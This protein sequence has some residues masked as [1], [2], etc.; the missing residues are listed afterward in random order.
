MAAAALLALLAC[1]A[2]P[3]GA[4]ADLTWQGL[5]TLS[6]GGSNTQQAT[7]AMN[8]GGEA[9]AAWYR[10][11]N[12]DT[13]LRPAGGNFAVPGVAIPGAGGD[14][15]DV[16][17]GVNG[18]AQAV[19]SSSDGSN[20][21]AAG[22]ARAPGSGFGSAGFI[23]PAGDNAGEPPV[24][25]VAP[26]G[27]AVALYRREI[28]EYVMGNSRA[29]GSSTWSS[30]SANPLSAQSSPF[31]TTSGPAAVAMDPQ[32]NAVA[33]WWRNVNNSPQLVEVRWRS[34]AGAWGPV[35]TLE[36][37]GAIS[38]YGPRVAMDGQGGA[39]AVWVGAGNVPHAA[40]RAPGTNSTFVSQ[41]VPAPATAVKDPRVAMDATGNGILTW[42]RG[43]RVEAAVR[44]AG[45]SF[46]A[47]SPISASGQTADQPALAMSSNGSAL[48]VWKQA[49]A[50][51]RIFGS[52]RPAAGNFSSQFELTDPVA[53]GD[54]SFPDVTMDNA[55]NA[56]AIWTRF[57]DG[58]VRVQ[59]RI[60][61]APGQTAPPPPPP[62]PEPPPPPPPVPG[63]PTV[64]AVKLAE[65]MA[66]DKAIVLTAQT[67]GPVDSVAWDLPIGAHIVGQT[68]SGQ[69]QRSV[70]FRPPP[71]AWDVRVRA[72]GAGRTGPLFTRHLASLRS[73]QDSETRRILNGLGSA[74]VAAVG[75]EADL[76]GGASS[77]SVRASG[78]CSIPTHIEAGQL[79]LDG[80]FKPVEKIADIPSAERGVLDTVARNVGIP[81]S[82]AGLMNKAMG[83]SDGYVAQGKA[84]L[85]DN[86]PVVPT[87]AA[88]IMAFPQARALTSSSASIEVAGQKFGASPKGFS[89]DLNPKKAGIDLGDIPKP[90]KLPSIG[91]FELVGDWNVDLGK[92]EATIKASLKLPKWITSAG[93]EIQNSVTLRATPE[94]LKVEDVSVGPIKANLGGLDVT[95]FKISFT[96]ATDTWQ[97]QA[98]A[99][100]ASGL[101]LDMVPPNGQVKI[102]HGKLNFAG[103]SLQFP[104]PGVP[105]FTG[106]NLERIGFGIGLDPTRF[107]GNA[108][109]AVLRLVKLDGR[110][111]VAFP[112][113]RTP[114]ILAADEVGGGFPAKLYGQKFTRPVIG[115]TAAVSVALP[116]L[117]LEL[118]HGYFLYHFPSYIAVGGGVSQNIL[119]VVSFAGGISGE[120]NFS[121]EVINVH[122]DI[123]VCLLHPHICGGAA[124]NI[125]RGPNSAGG[126]GGCVS[127]G[128]LSVGG[129]VLWRG[130]KII[131]WPLDGC[132]WSRFKLDVNA[133]RAQA[134][135]PRTIVVKA[136][137]PSPVLKLYGQGGAP[138]VHVAGPGGQV[139]DTTDR[140]LDY[141]PDAK[142]RILR[143]EGQNYNFTTI[144]I[145]HGQPG[146][147]T[148]TP[149][150]G[151][152]PI[153]KVERATDQPNAGVTGHVT[154]RGTQRVL[155]YRVLKRDGQTV[156]F[157]DVGEG[158]ASR[159]IGH[160]T[161]GGTGAIKFSAAPGKA[162]RRVEAQFALDG[163]NA[164][165]KVVT[166]FRPPA[167]T[168]PVPRGLRVKRGK[169]GLT[170]SWRGVAGASKYE[171]GI[172]SPSGYQ[173]IIITRKR[174][175]VVKLAKSVGGR[176]TVRA[177]APFRTSRVTAKPFRRLASRATKFRTP[178]RCRVVKKR[179][180]C[181]R[182]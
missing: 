83:L 77:A 73:S 23:S 30:D 174:R 31:Q 146:T 84:M 104:P 105:L 100:I 29:A 120:A 92:R 129:G 106:I 124:A 35:Q 59:S 155:H 171:L 33:A 166:T 63:V 95:G 125:S 15:P 16:A 182:A 165:R 18:H 41:T 177:G 4:S 34:A 25:A 93:I 143:S 130:P 69:L 44:P 9:V 150:P 175:V 54:A 167:L 152:V 67:A 52:Y 21:R 90:P 89:L 137:Q 114:Y 76:T 42:V 153:T 151:S 169:K 14:N 181:R 111:V 80:C 168:L 162:R 74:D 149:L 157:F 65:P 64:T 62:P 70:R 115:A 139:L 50:D 134:D 27:N 144:G 58:N 123:Q 28:W 178:K 172:T 94:E 51:D 39:L 75:A 131:V 110:I 140:G 11:G 57:A 136:G 99:C 96:K 2:F 86:W 12:I 66:R 132:K 5:G 48:A 161:G 179:I 108:R 17:I 81:V 60:G 101:C 87:G 119:D 6:L 78:R 24:T 49:G 176:V 109:I 1:L 68:F 46:S 26:A 135:A 97:G 163:L 72:S 85:N 128:P 145:E 3:V 45:G 10:G 116:G 160:I 117:E 98:K 180:V 159:E 158:D 147:Y 122:G 53:A 118:G 88:D 71:G 19:W 38:A 142:I 61:V 43:G 113:E 126:A 47:G 133:S 103:A 127:L 102:V 55:G 121:D 148:V 82:D 7:I 20:N 112:S 156:R 170:I 79:D 138:R 13:S 141:T 154:G 56:I 8:A 107:T 36:T 164:E 40:Y 173:R 22:A 37:T 91:G 32:G